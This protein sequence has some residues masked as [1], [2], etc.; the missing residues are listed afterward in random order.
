MCQLWREGNWLAGDNAALSPHPPH[1]TESDIYWL[2]IKASLIH[3]LTKTSELVEP[4]REEQEIS[5]SRICER[6][7]QCHGSVHSSGVHSMVLVRVQYNLAVDS[8]CKAAVA[9]PKGFPHFGVKKKALVSAVCQFGFTRTYIPVHIYTHDFF[10]SRINSS[11]DH[12]CMLQ[13]SSSVGRVGRDICSHFHV[14]LVVSARSG[15][16]DFIMVQTTAIC[17]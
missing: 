13:R 3:F 2:Q 12:A 17:L 16:D 10:G 6:G 7:R 1:G 5:V 8:L 11:A 9:A 4:C 15:L 14:K